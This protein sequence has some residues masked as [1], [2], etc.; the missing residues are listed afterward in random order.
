M[1]KI[2]LKP[3]FSTPIIFFGTIFKKLRFNS[4]VG[5]LIFG[6]VFS[7]VVNIVTV[8]LQEMI[9]K[10]RILEAIENEILTNTLTAQEIFTAND[11]E[12]K[13]KETPNIFHPFFRYSNDLWTQSSEPLQYIAQL[14]QQT[15]IDIHIYYTI[16]IKHGNNMVEK[17]DEISRKK[18]E[19]CY[20]FSILNENE[21]EVCNQNY[22]M[23]LNWE[24]DTAEGM[25]NDGLDLLK[26]F[27]PTKDRKNNFILSILMGNKSTKILSGETD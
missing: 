4:F 10:Q 15:Q 7:L 21:K 13:E 1:T 19:N 12:I 8:Q 11:K 18:L 9:Q 17:Y 20:E 6:A 14:D 3:I 25:S 23:I 24:A 26:N 27:H 22:W 16:A 2:N 5:G